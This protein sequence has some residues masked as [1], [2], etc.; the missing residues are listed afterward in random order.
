[1][2]KSKLAVNQGQAEQTKDNIVGY[3]LKAEFE[4]RRVH[5]SRM[6]FLSPNNLETFMRPEFEAYKEVEKLKV[7]D[8]WFDPV[9]IKVKEMRGFTFD[10]ET[11][12]VEKGSGWAK[13]GGVSQ[14][15][16]CFIAYLAEIEE[17]IK[18]MQDK[19]E[20]IEDMVRF[21]EQQS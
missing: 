17:D 20:K 14:N 1:M 10:D 16:H 21:M 9:F 4:D 7:L 11:W 19:K 8:V 18:E 13:F 3:K 5:I 15:T 12:V 6:L 2:E